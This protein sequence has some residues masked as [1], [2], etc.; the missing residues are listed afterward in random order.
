MLP[1]WITETDDGVYEIDVNVSYP[2]LLGELKASVDK[3]PNQDG[4]TELPF[5]AELRNLDL[6]NLTQYWIEVAYQMSKL[7]VRRYLL[8]MG[9]NAWPNMFKIKGDKSKWGI[10]SFPPGRGIEAATQGKEAREHYK[11]LRGFLPN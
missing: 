2:L 6:D 3:L 10:K 9:G 1:D 4:A 7:E 11:R 8:L 5:L